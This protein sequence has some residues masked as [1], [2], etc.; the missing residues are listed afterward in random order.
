[1]TL[2]V[3]FGRIVNDPEASILTRKALGRLET[4]GLLVTDEG[5]TINNDGRMVLR[6]TPSLSQNSDGL[7]VRISA[8][9][10]IVIGDDG[11]ELAPFEDIVCDN[12][13]VNQNAVVGGALTVTGDANFA[14]NAAVGGELSVA[15][16]FN[17]N[18]INSTTI[19]NSGNISSDTA[20]FAGAVSVGGV[21]SSGDINSSG[22]IVAVGNVTSN[23]VL[24]NSVVTTT[25]TSGSGSFSGNVLIGGTLGVT[26]ATTLAAVSAT[27]ASVSGNA[28]VGGTLGV[29]GNSTL[30]SA[31]ITGNASV[32]G[33]LTTGSFTTGNINASIINATHL[34]LTGDIGASRM[35]IGAGGTIITRVLLFYVTATFS[36]GAGIYPLETFAPIPGLGPNDG[37][38]VSISGGTYGGGFVS[39]SA[40]TVG[41]GTI[42]I[43]VWIQAT[44]VFSVTP[45]FL[46][47]ALQ[48]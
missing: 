24:A 29:T 43:R 17:G 47:T 16:A 2:S 40:A 27:S 31:T 37:L 13:I 44:A 22:N 10:G 42:M 38:S 39:W 20:N 21:L 3:G 14:G 34:N 1:M 46:V 28:T 41:F 26:G 19:I 25:I 8:D 7:A 45:T 9:G 11:L 30:A 15:G 4:P 33:A 6:L 5:L 36:G 48:A 23:A 32:G 18:I 35:Q 12:I